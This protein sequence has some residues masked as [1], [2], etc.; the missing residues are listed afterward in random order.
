MKRGVNNVEE[1]V[2]K[3]FKE[4]F[5]EHVRHLENVSEDLISLAYGPDPRVVVHSA[6]NV[7]GAR[8]R[9]VDRDK[10]L[11]T[12]NSGVM[13]KAI[14]GNEHEET[15]YYGVVKEVLELTYMKNKYGDRSVVLFRCDW[16]DLE[17]RLTKMKDDGYFKSVNT[18]KLWYKN[19]PF[20]LASQA[21]TCFYVDDTKLGA[22]WKVV[23]NFS[24]RNLFDVPEKEDATEVIDQL[25]EDAYQEDT[26]TSDIIVNDV[27]LEN[28]VDDVDAEADLV[29]PRE[30][31]EHVDA[32]IV[33][34]LE[35]ED[36]VDDE[37]QYMSE[38]EQLVDDGDGVPT[39][40]DDEDTD[41]E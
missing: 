38:G 17:G 30:D 31:L 11:R 19:A 13:N 14:Y 7:N 23:Q 20:I 26:G 18:S 34:E 10:N 37:A 16:F 29:D 3:G 8:F 2:H 21:K 6:C 36:E 33:D 32:R 4:W 25:R 22:P 41:V 1:E 24:H 35:R 9:T 5:K 12:Q 28:E 40:S 15:E 39:N 27:V